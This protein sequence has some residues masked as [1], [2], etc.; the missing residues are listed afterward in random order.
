MNDKNTDISKNVPVI[1]ASTPQ[2]NILDSSRELYEV[3]RVEESISLFIN[4]HLH[5]LKEGFEKLNILHPFP[6]QELT[7]AI[8]QL[9][10]NQKIINNNLKISCFV[11]NQKISPYYVYAI[12]SKYPDTST[13]ADGVK[14]ALVYAERDNPNIKIGH[15]PT[16][17]LANEE[18]QRKDVHE[19][20]LVDHKGRITE[21]SRSNVFF[22][23]KDTI[24]TAPS[25]IV[26]QG[27]MRK[28]VLEIIDQCKLNLK[29]ECLPAAELSKINAA[30]ITGTSP[31]IL[32]ISHI[33][34]INL[35]VTNTLLRLLMNKLSEMITAYKTSSS[36][37]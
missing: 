30:F 12:P 6:Q 20:L 16:R 13:Y 31:R 37:T 27:I 15:T 32:P 34:A 7:Q 28:K 14:T 18:I 33:D 2:E 10:K 23:I 26:L 4:D 1:I 24:Y 17:M 3:L 29:M 9:I 22:I 19:V 35:D 8:Y 11:D 5:R 25:N 36:L 21:G